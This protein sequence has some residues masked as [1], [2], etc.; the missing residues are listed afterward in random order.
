MANCALRK[1][2]GY[3]DMEA[4]TEAVQSFSDEQL[5]RTMKNQAAPRFWEAFR[6]PDDYAYVRRWA[7]IVRREAR[8]RGLL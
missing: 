1:S 7:S 2:G 8:R 5:A 4:M 6:A 3:K